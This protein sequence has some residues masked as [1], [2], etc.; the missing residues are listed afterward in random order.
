L[1]SGL[2]LSDVAH[3]ADALLAGDSHGREQKLDV[4]LRVAEGL[5]AI[6][7][8]RRGGLQAGGVRLGAGHQHLVG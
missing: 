1:N 2:F 3:G 8:V 5:L 4:L 6:E 7:Q